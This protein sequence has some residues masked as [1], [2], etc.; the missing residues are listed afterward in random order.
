MRAPFVSLLGAAAL[1][2]VCLPAAAHEGHVHDGL[3]AGLAHPLGG[4]DHLL[5]TLGIGL[6]AGVAV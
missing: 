5:A 2:T 6:L 4:A 1:A 3:L